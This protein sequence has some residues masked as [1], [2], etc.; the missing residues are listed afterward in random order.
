MNAQ[1]AHEFPATELRPA[2]G[3]DHAAG[4]VA[5]AGDRF[6]EDRV[7][8]DHLSFTVAGADELRASV[9][10]LDELGIAHEPVKDTGPLS[11]L[12][13]RDPD[14]IALEISAAN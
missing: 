7:G 1:S 12:E 5:A 13:F 3:V 8:L 4:H 2:V 14:G 9:A 11:I 6:D 10:V